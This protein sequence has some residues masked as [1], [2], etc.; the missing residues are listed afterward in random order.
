M[1]NICTIIPES[2]Y[3]HLL[4]LSGRCGSSAWSQSQRGRARE[5]LHCTHGH[6]SDGE[7]Q[8][9]LQTF[10]PRVCSA[11]IFGKGEWKVS[12]GTV[13]LSN[14]TQSLVYKT[15]LTN[16]LQVWKCHNNHWGVV[17][18]LQINTTVNQTVDL[19]FP[20]LIP[21]V[22]VQVCVTAWFHFFLFCFISDLGNV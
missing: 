19:S 17:F 7:D 8:P 1:T 3:L 6:G 20:H 14:K 11:E 5:T 13:F 2:V 21:C 15:I 16:D 10:I 12:S 22:C 9:V 18:V 4:C